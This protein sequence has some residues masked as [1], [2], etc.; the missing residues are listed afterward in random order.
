M[1]KIV[2]IL[3]RVLK[4]FELVNILGKGKDSVAQKNDKPEERHD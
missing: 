4:L 1:K 3:R 2:I